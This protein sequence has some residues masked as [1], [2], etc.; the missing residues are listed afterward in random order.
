[1]KA[2]IILLGM[3]IST[4]L[5]S[6][7]ITKTVIPALIVFWCLFNIFI[8]YI[9]ATMFLN[10]DYMAKKN[11]EYNE[12]PNFYIKDYSFS[13]LKRDFPVEGFL[14]YVRLSGD[15]RY[16]ETFRGDFVTWLEMQNAGIALIMSLIIIVGIV[17]KKL[18]QIT[19]AIL[20]LIVSSMQ[21]YGTILYFLSYYTKVYKNVENKNGKWFV[22]LFLFNLPW[23]VV[24]IILLAYSINI[25][26][27]PNIIYVV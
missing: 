7:M 17:S 15:T 27:K 1:M 14:E 13:S 10:Q 21:L 23:I 2:I 12:N 18:S 3:T 25:I 11:K 20:L 26:K 5:I 8:A 6:L 4:F 19:I 9:E 22:H 24:P 16:T